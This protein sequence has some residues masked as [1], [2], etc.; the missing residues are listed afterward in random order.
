MSQLGGDRS[1]L[2]SHGIE[3][4]E[5]ATMNLCRRRCGPSL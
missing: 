4:R 3:T 1:S 2:G 5:P